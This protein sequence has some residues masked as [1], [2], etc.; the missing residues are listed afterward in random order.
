M[1]TRIKYLPLS[2]L[3]WLVFSLSFSHVSLAQEQSNKI[4]LPL[5]QHNGTSTNEGALV[6]P[7]VTIKGTVEQ[8]V[9]EYTADQTII[10]RATVRI[11]EVLEGNFNHDRL[12]IRYTG[13][14]VGDVTLRVSHQP[15]LATGMEVRAKVYLQ[16]NGEFAIYDVVNDLTVFNFNVVASY[17]TLSYRWPTGNL[18][19]AIQINPNNIDVAGADEGIAVRNAMNTWNKY[20]GSFFEFADRGNSACNAPARDNVNCV[21]WRDTQ[22]NGT[23]L[24]TTYS[25]F[26]GNQLTDSDIIFYGL[27]AGNIDY[28][29]ST[30]PN[31]SNQFDVESVALHELGHALGLDHESCCNDVMNPAIGQNQ[32]KRSL[33]TD[34]LN[35][36]MAQYP[37][38]LSSS[39]VDGAWVTD[40]FTC[41]Q[42]SRCRTLLRGVKHVANNGN[43]IIRTGNYPETITINRPLTLSAAN[44]LVTIGK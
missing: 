28:I 20:T 15:L 17:V 29:W 31:G 4:Y 18:P 38:T 1:N 32:I 5:V 6:Q 37:P 25:W 9:S 24:A 12:T 2:L 35:G 41:D 40:S 16:E 19:I 43:V 8:V 36:V 44:G 34:D 3:C 22:S 23:A 26:T 39:F 14:T 10:S 13:G 7:F 21:V 11:E 30:N 27:S 33:T 42:Y